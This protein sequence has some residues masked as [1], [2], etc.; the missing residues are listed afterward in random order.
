MR[1]KVRC[2]VPAACYNWVMPEADYWCGK[3]EICLWAVA[4]LAWKKG[5]CHRRAAFDI[6][7]QHKTALSFKTRNGL[8]NFAMLPKYYIV[9]ISPIYSISAIFAHKI[10]YASFLYGVLISTLLLR[11]WLFNA[12]SLY[13]FLRGAALRLRQV[14]RNI[15]TSRQSS[16]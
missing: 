11:P 8:M 2:H 14:V 15:Q 16:H 10:R 13:C 7:F 5:V 12:N 3:R 9:K 1:S 6:N 4:H